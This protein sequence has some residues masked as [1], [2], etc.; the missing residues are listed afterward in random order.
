[1][2][3]PSENEQ[4]GILTRKTGPAERGPIHAEIIPPVAGKENVVTV[5]CPEPVWTL[6]GP[7]ASYRLGPQGTV[8]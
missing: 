4:V 2:F 1:M 7:Y 3:S 6:F 8:P 5:G